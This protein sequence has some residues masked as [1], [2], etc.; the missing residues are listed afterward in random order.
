MPFQ[1]ISEGEWNTTC[2]FNKISKEFH[3]VQYPIKLGQFAKSA[4]ITLGLGAVAKGNLLPVGFV[5]KG[6]QTIPVRKLRKLYLGG[7]AHFELPV[8]Y[9]LTKFQI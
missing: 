9:Q 8:Q 6:S 4:Q 5:D 1:Q 3:A 2:K 7:L